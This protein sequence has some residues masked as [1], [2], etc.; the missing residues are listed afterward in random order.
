MRAGVY[1]GKP[2]HLEGRRVQGDL[3]GGRLPGGRL[4]EVVENSRGQS[5]DGSFVV[6]DLETTGL[7]AVNN[8]II[9]I[10]AVKVE[11]ERSQSG[12]VPL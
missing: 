12:S 4:K 11:E 7:S 1:R 10:G 9:E 2:Y 3:R 6:F 8:R 5:L